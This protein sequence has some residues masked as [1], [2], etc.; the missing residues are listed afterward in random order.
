MVSSFLFFFVLFG[1]GQMTYRLVWASV[2]AHG[3]LEFFSGSGNKVKMDLLT[4]KANKN[5]NKKKVEMG[6][7]ALSDP[8][9]S[10]HN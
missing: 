8:L 7:A 9:N 4:K 6:I 3:P 5:K 2:W 10:T 1:L